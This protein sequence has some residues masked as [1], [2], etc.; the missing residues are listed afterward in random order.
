M[1]ESCSTGRGLTGLPNELLAAI[2]S[3]L[4]AH[5]V[6]KRTTN[7]T[8]P[9]GAEAEWWDYGRPA[10]GSAGIGPAGLLNLNRV[11]K[12]L[13]A[14]AEPFLYH[15][16]RTSRRRH[17]WIL[18]DTLSN[19][20]DLALRV[21]AVD[22]AYPLRAEEMHPLPR[23]LPPSVL[24]AAKESVREARSMMLRDGNGEDRIVDLD[25]LDE[26]VKHAALVSMLL[27]LVPNAEAARF[28]LHSQAF[29]G[30]AGIILSRTPPQASL[31]SLAFGSLA[32]DG[33]LMLDQTAPVLRLAPNLE[34]LHFDNC[35]AVSSLFAASL[36]RGS[37]A[38]QSLLSGLA[39]LSLADSRLSV[40]ALAA[41]LNAVGPRL[42]RFKIRRS[43]PTLSFGD[44][45]TVL[46]PWK[47][48]LTELTILDSHGGLSE[49]I[50]SVTGILLLRDFHALETL[51]VEA[52]DL[53]F[54]DF[55]SR[56][57]GVSPLFPPSL[58]NVRLRGDPCRVS[59]VTR[60]PLLC[61]D[62]RK[63]RRLNI[64]LGQISSDASPPG[65]VL[66]LDDR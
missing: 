66:T 28:R 14:V 35:A 47:D 45:L 25:D 42:S 52:A 32:D 26:V 23:S 64:S 53:E 1:S 38:G 30:L 51:C 50:G 57:P 46:R 13:R 41:L 65:E 12:S 2:C 61:L 10:S 56:Q 55:L 8:W 33:H 44:V 5:C 3:Y 9:L 20:R 4:C 7:S 49:P 22:V 39:E 27:Q 19:R 60:S 40:A 24:D 59:A 43:A 48:T 62:P 31:R 16:P 36:D 54:L 34:A 29:S 37:P 6:C 17:L 15:F 18:V 21:A 11:C 58:R 63:G